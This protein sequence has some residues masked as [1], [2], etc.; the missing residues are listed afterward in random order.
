MKVIV[1]QGFVVHLRKQVEINGRPEI[2]ESSFYE[3]QPTNMSEQ[4][5]LDNLHKLEPGDK[6][7]TAFFASR[8]VPE[9]TKPVE[10][11]TP[12]DLQKMLAAAAAQGAAAAIAAM[13]TSGQAAPAA[14]PAAG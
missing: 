2:Q 11:L 1:R 3:G 10:G 14:D 12:A 5:V 6:E 13:Q 8:F 7:A 9:P 4:D